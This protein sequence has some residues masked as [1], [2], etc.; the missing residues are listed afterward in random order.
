M[1]MTLRR[2]MVIGDGDD[3]SHNDNSNNGEELD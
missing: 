3:G 1:V 2:R